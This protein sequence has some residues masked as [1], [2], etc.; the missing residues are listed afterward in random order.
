M[1]DAAAAMPYPFVRHDDLTVDARYRELQQRGPIMVELPYGEPLWLATRY[2][3]AKTVYGDSRFGKALGVGRD[4]PRMH[5]LRHGDDPTMLVNMDPPAQT[6][7][8][9]LT[10]AAFSPAKIRSLRSW[11]E[12]IADELLDGMLRDGSPADFSAHVAWSLPLKVITGILGVREADIPTFRVWVD[13]LVGVD[14]PNERRGE[15]Y[16]SLTDYIRSLVAERRERSTDD[17]LS[18]LVQ[19]RDAEDR[20]SEDELI[21]LAFALFLAGFETTAAQIGSTVYTLLAHRD[22]WQELVDDRAVMP[23]ALEELWRW[24]PSFRYGTPMIRWASED[25]ELSDGV[26]IPAGHAV[27]AEHE[28]ANRDESV[29]PHGWELDFHRVAPQPHLSLAWGAHRCLGAHLAHLELEV[30]LER[31]LDRMP[32]LDLAVAPENVKWSPTTFLRSVQELPVT[33]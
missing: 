26:V 12:G 9:R 25:V 5:E 33:W 15:L 30:T 20:L 2:T 31:L 24:I 4:T 14:T 22:L 19:A 21:S 7:V 18:V 11:V 32:A 3:D 16:V 6:R 13:E 1:T 28:V 27:L 23:A 10:F 8:R 29:F 17:L